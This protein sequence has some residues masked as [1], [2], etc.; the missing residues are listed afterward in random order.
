MLIKARMP[1]TVTGLRRCG[2][3]TL[4]KII[5][6]QLKLAHDPYLYVNFN[7]ER[8][9]HFDMD[10]FQKILDFLHEQNYQDMPFLFLDEVQET[11]GWEK[12]V[13]RINPHFHIILT[14]SNSKL[15]SREIS[16]VLTGRTLSLELFPFSFYEY[17]VAR[18]IEMNSWRLDLKQ[19][20]QLRAAFHEYLMFGGMPQYVMTG[21]ETIIAELYENILFRDIIARHARNLNK[22]IKEIGLYKCTN[23]ATLFSFRKLAKMIDVKNIATVK[24][25]LESLEASYLFLTSNKF[26][27][28]KRKQVT[29]PKK[30]YVIDNGF[31][32]EKLSLDDHTI[33]IEPAWKWLLKRALS[34]E[35]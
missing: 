7:D 20:S 12:W 17:A 15:S 16:T 19:Q 32:E 18:Q 11:E 27:F 25:I 28:S 4:L 6:N 2:K 3:S 10:D 5:K 34:S 23:P 31:I 30:L 24:S 22:A 21:V 33:L 29:N 14:G 13:D 35:V 26:D 8:L 9:L 1:I